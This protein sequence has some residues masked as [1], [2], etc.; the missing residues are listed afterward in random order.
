MVWLLQ[1]TSRW[2][3]F[4]VTWHETYSLSE[5]TNFFYL[6]LI[7]AAITARKKGR[8]WKLFHVVLCTTSIPIVFTH[9]SSSWCFII[10]F[11]VLVCVCLCVFNVKCGQFVLELVSLFCVYF[12]VLIV[13]GCHCQYHRKQLS[14]KTR[15]R[16]DLGYPGVQ[17]DIK[18][19]I[20]TYQWLKFSRTQ[21]NA[22][23]PPPV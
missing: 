8:L 7:V 22:V 9:V 1:F 10:T 23:L 16:N 4:C 14:G 2:T 21:R 20:L 6:P 18:P 3:S 12:L 13:I 17:W 15:R 5:F 11:E 19:C